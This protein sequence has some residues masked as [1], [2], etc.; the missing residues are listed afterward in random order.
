MLKEYKKNFFGL[1]WSKASF[2][3][4]VYCSR[5]RVANSQSINSMQGFPGDY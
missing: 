4:Y 1:A 5:D 3:I 2:C